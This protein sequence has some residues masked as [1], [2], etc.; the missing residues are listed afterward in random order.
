MLH[1][2]VKTIIGLLTAVIALAI[3]PGAATAGKAP[4]KAPKCL[5]EK[6]TIVGTKK[7]DDLRGTN[8]AGRDRGPR[9]Q[10]RHHRQGGQRR[11]LHR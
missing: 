1:N 10:R 5:G 6:A 7:A 9:G 2:T 8:R 4:P 11:D 3:L